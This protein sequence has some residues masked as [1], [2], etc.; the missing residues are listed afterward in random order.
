MPV[1]GYTSENSKDVDVGS[2]VS[3]RCSAIVGGYE[4]SSPTVSSGPAAS[5]GP[6]DD[7][8]DSSERAQ[9]EDDFF[10][11]CPNCGSFFEPG[12][13]CPRIAE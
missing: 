7:A 2:D 9:T 6:D 8:V 4:P 12:T 13:H 11:V 1:V 5:P 10:S 3:S